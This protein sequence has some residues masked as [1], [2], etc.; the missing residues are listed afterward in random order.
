MSV[1]Y[2]IG[3]GWK[4]RVARHSPMEILAHFSDKDG[5]LEEGPATAAMVHL[6]TDELG[7]TD[8]V[9]RALLEATG[10]SIMKVNDPNAFN[11]A[12]LAVILKM[13]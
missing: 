1:Q 9:L 2:C 11:R 13:F 4:Y 8:P 5:N 10:A 7:S 3:Y 6:L 12:F